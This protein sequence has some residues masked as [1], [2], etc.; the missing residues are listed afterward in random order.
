MQIVINYY[1]DVYLS[2]SGA[3]ASGLIAA[4]LD[5]NR[6]KGNMRRHSKAV[7][8]GNKVEHAI[9]YL[10]NPPKPTK[11]I[12]E[13]AL[14]NLLARVADRFAL[15]CSIKRSMNV[16]ER[17]EDQ[18]N[19][20]FVAFGFEEDHVLKIVGEFDEIMMEHGWDSLTVS[21]AK[22]DGSVERVDFKMKNTARYSGMKYNLNTKM[23]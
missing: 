1:P 4:P 15:S 21:I 3:A 16:T 17:S 8:K 22:L 5:P 14:K 19:F 20:A 11:H 10:Y 7:F 18:I 23:I 12:S 9:S 6:P 13:S 2:E